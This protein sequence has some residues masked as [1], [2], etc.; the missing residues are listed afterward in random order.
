LATTLLSHA[1]GRFAS[2][3][4]NRSGQDEKRA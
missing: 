3:R 2:Q 1:A 4:P